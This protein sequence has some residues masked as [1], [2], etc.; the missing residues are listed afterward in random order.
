MKKALCRH[1]TGILILFVLTLVCVG[2]VA[3]ADA[4]PS[5]RFEEE[6]ISI[7]VRYT[8]RVSPV[9]ENVEN[10]RSM[11]YVWTSDD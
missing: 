8:T 4:E 6:E 10:P 9:A 3:L 2:G 1:L 7:P 11:K 5:L